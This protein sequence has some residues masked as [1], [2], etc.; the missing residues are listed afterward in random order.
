MSTATTL[1]PMAFVPLPLGRIR[2]AGWL[3][4]QLRIQADGLTGHLDEFWPDV[5]NSRWV[6]GDGDGW[7]RGPYWLDGLVPLAFL[8]NDAKLTEKAHRWINAILRDQHA[9]GWLGYVDPNAKPENQ[10]DPWPRYIVLKAMI[11]YYEAT[12]DARI[13]PAMMRFMHS[14]SARLNGQP[15]TSWAQMRYGDLLLCTH[16]LFEQTGEVWLLDFAAKVQRQGFDWRGLYANFPYTER[17]ST[18]LMDNHVVNNAM[19]IKQPGVWWR[20]SRDPEDRAA[21]YR[22]IETLD[23]YH[24]QA[25]G[26]FTGDETLAG[27]NPSQGT[28]LCAVVEYM[29]SLEQLVAILGDP[30]LADRL[31]RIAYNAL[32][33]T[34][35]PDMWAHQYDQQANQ[36]ICSV[37]EDYIYTTNRGEANIYG[38]QPHFGCCLANMHQGWP[39][40]A[41][42]LWMEIPQGGLA[43]VA[44]APCVVDA[45]CARVRVET[46]YP[47]DD[48]IQITVAGSGRFPLALRVPAWTEEA[49]ISIGGDTLPLRAG[50]FHGLERDWSGQTTFTLHLPMPVRTQTRYRGSA[51]IERGPLVYA[52]RVGDEWR[53]LKG[54]EP[55]ADWEVHPTTPWNYALELDREH[56]ERS[57]EF[58]ALPVGECPF[59]P[60]G[61][62][63]RVW[64]RGRRVPG[65]ELEHNAAGP[66]PESPVRTSE[67]LK[68]LELIPYG[69]TNLRVTEFPT[70]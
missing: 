46:D 11:Q 47:F 32:P 37:S 16:W 14:L 34:F 3:A 24:G 15:L 6:G 56:P 43:A 66:I 53:Y 35:K 45:P 57:L 23:R 8:L 12:H 20:Q 60:E 48:Q 67:P 50:T 33:A 51:S 58:T 64:A 40:F 30:V 19:A 10:Y 7:E 2:P 68:D 18:W 17:Q 62:P 69:C 26:I 25:T 28:E 36:V 21:V 44:Y 31:E 13:L 4:N 54:E 27:L 41:A 61:A 55:H 59:S 49:T 65:W 38:L 1:E 9:D 5:A 22:I 29:F 70:L 42:H 52:L 63:I 39:K